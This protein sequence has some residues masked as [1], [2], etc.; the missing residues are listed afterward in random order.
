MS[1]RLLDDAQ[2][3]NVIRLRP[4]AFRSVVNAETPDPAQLYNLT[5]LAFLLHTPTGHSPVCA[6]CG[7][8]WPCCQVRLAYRIR[9]GF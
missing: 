1:V 6:T 8:K 3:T 5:V 4:K 7:E 9:E 2:P